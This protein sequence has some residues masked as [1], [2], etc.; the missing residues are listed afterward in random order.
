M[1]ITKNHPSICNV[2][3][4]YSLEGGVTS[5]QC[6]WLENGLRDS[7]R[8]VAE[9]LHHCAGRLHDSAQPSL[10]CMMPLAQLSVRPFPS[11]CPADALHDG[12]EV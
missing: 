8:L 12:A 11:E 4:L 5:C 1:I 7:T 2:S 6:V 10:A 9:P 3:P